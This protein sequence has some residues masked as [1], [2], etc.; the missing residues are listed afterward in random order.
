M[1]ATLSNELAQLFHLRRVGEF[2]EVLPRLLGEGRLVVERLFAHREAKARGDAHLGGGRQHAA[3]GDVVDG[4]DELAADRLGHQPVRLGEVRQI[5]AVAGGD[6]RDRVAMALEVHRHAVAH[7]V[8]H[9]DGADQQRVG[10]ANDLAGLLVGELVVQR[11]LAA[12]ERDAVGHG[13]VVA[14]FAGANQLAHASRGVSTLGQQKL[15][16]IAIW[17]GSAPTATTL[18]IASSMEAMAIS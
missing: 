11:V 13:G 1:S 10:D 3:V 2:D 16:R 15:S 4:D 18:R 5:A 9:R 12:D 14:G 6:H 7:I 8:D 17:A